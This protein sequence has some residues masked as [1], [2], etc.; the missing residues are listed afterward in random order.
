MEQ[1]LRVAVLVRAP[2]YG[3]MTAGTDVH[4]RHDGENRHPEVLPQ[5]AIFQLARL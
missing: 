5:N 3:A 2:A 4:I 1:V